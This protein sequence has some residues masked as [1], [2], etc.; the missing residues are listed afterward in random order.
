MQHNLNCILEY[1]IIKSNSIKEERSD[2]IYSEFFGLLEKNVF[3]PP[4][5]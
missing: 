4:I 5:S 1:K 2:F 3:A